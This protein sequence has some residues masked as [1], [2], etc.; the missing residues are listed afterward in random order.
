MLLSLPVVKDRKVTFTGW[1]K[2]MRKQ[3]W[4]LR[5]YPKKSAP[6]NRISAYVFNPGPG[7]G[8]STYVEEHLKPGKWVHIVA[9]FDSGD[10]TNPKAG[11][12][13]YKDGRLAGSPQKSPGALYKSYD[14]VPAVGDAPMRIGTRERSVFHRSHRRGGG[15]SSRADAAPISNDCRAGQSG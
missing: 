11:V 14:V 5:F 7:L 2:E 10:K 15:L 9:T 6:P 12:S 8:S 3:E 1:A 13:I 4:A